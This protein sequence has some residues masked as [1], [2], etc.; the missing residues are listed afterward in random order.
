[1]PSNSS[2]VQ[3]HFPSLPLKPAYGDVHMHGIPQV[4]TLKQVI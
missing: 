3:E 2:K 1:M 4:N